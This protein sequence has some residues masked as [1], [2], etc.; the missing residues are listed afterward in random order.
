MNNKER[1]RNSQRGGDQ[2]DKMIKHGVGSWIVLWTRKRTLVE[3]LVKYKVCNFVN[4]KC[5]CKCF[6]FDMYIL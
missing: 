1:L 2:G 3:K 6:P 5:Q 4:N